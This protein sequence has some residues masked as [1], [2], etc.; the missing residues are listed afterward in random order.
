[1]KRLAL[2]LFCTLNLSAAVTGPVVPI[3][4][5]EQD[6]WFDGTDNRFTME[7]VTVDDP[8]NPAHPSLSGGY[9]VGDV[10]YVFR[11]Q[12]YTASEDQF[13][14]VDVARNLVGGSCPYI[15]TNKPA[16]QLCIRE[17]MRFVN[18]LNESKGY[19]KAYN[20]GLDGTLYVW[21]EAQR[22]RSTNGFRHKDCAYALPT[23]H[24]H[25]KTA[26]WDSGSQTWQLY[27][28]GGTNAPTPVNGWY[29]N[30][31]TA[32][33]TA[34]YSQH[35]DERYPEWNSTNQV[36]VVI[37][38]TGSSLATVTYD[39]FIRGHSL[40]QDT[41]TPF[42]VTQGGVVGGRARVTSYSTLTVPA[43]F[44]IVAPG[45]G[46]TDGE[47]A[48]MTFDS[49]TIDVQVFADDTGAVIG[50]YPLGKRWASTDTSTAIAIVGTGSSA[51]ARVSRYSTTYVPAAITVTTAS[52]GY[53]NGAATMSLGAT[54]YSPYYLINE[55]AADVDRAGGESPFGAVGMFGNA[56]N[57]LE[58]PS[59][60]I[61]DKDDA[62]EPLLYVG[63]WW[64]RHAASNLGL[65][66][67][68]WR[69][70]QCLDGS[71]GANSFRVVSLLP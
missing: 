52:S 41:T 26:M 40:S 20:I 5:G 71:Y 14:K 68:S 44:V 2:L 29:H 37:T 13:R 53:S 39:S 17:I 4:H 31:S 63:F 16:G 35:F 21:P 51:T 8:G 50:L 49:A 70:D 60:W 27:G 45:S 22:W 30:G 59:D 66:N 9:L 61:S 69:C 48:T 25:F 38:V 55:G 6:V 23:V 43:E 19:H 47:V 1:M 3:D 56:S 54:D 33:G 10:D 36:N 28:Q 58:T 64:F 12:K 34:I 24:E 18:A 62:Q 46:Y 7:F 15:G 65:G 32:A 67:E 57:L 11:E 42:V